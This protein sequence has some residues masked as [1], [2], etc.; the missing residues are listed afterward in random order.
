MN[1]QFIK[2][3]SNLEEAIRD[4]KSG[5]YTEN[6]FMNKLEDT[7]HFIDLTLRAKREVG[8]QEVL[9]NTYSYQFS[10]NPTDFNN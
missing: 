6:E 5:L 3:I 4:W 2:E 1:T 10:P 7:C 8:F 9:E